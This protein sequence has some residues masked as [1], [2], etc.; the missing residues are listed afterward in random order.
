MTFR[1]ELLY[2]KCYAFLPLK[3]GQYTKKQVVKLNTFR[4]LQL[5]TCYFRKSHFQ[6]KKKSEYYPHNGL[7]FFSLK[8][9]NS[10]RPAIYLLICWNGTVTLICNT[11]HFNTITFYFTRSEFNED[12]PIPWIF[13]KYMFFPILKCVIVRVQK[14][15]KI[16]YTEKQFL[17]PKRLTISLRYNL[18][19]NYVC[20]SKPVCLPPLSSLTFFLPLK[21]YSKTWH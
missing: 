1:N 5:C 15:W 20:K 17:F 2:L 11:L 16:K 18:S 3:Y 7:P 14:F 10:W 8:S 12:I 21:C 9:I 19:I 4:S 6:K 13:F